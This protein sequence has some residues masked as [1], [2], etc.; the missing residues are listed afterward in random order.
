MRRIASEPSA[1]SDAARAAM[2]ASAIPT[3]AIDTFPLAPIPVFKS[4]FSGVGL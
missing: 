4:S 2:S 3:L 1:L